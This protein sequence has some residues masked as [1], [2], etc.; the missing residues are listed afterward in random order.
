M[1]VSSRLTLDVTLA[2][3]IVIIIIIIIIMMVVMSMS[4]LISAISASC[5]FYSYIPHLPSPFSFPSLYPYHH[6]A[7]GTPITVDL[8]RQHI[9]R[10]NGDIIAFDIDQ[11]RKHCLLNGLDDIGLTMQK[12]PLISK[13]ENERRSIAPWFDNAS[14]IYVD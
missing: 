1:Q 3:T 4:I 12:L 10:S 13:F 7:L 9:H 6:V 8:E 14:Q 11:F 5:S 2:T